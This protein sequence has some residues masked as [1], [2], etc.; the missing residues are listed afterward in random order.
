MDTTESTMQIFAKAD[1]YKSQYQFDDALKYYDSIIDNYKNH[2][3]NDDVLFRKAEIY[4]STYHYDKAIE[5]L[6]S[7]IEEYPS[8]LL[9]D[10][11]LFMLGEIYE[12]KIKNLEKAK[13]YY[14]TLLF[15]HSGSLFVIEARKR[16]RKL[17]GSTNEIINKNS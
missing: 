12:S 7:L 5:N 1:M 14:K 4:T 13:E 8:S 11:S 17:A 15:D 2:S 9:I 10:N 6:E 16:F 3:L